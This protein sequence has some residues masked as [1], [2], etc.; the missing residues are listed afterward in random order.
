MLSDSLQEFL[1]ILPFSLDP[2]QLD[3]IES[4]SG[5]RSVLVSAPTGTGKTVVA[6]Y[7][8]HQ[9]LS[10]GLRAIYTTPIKALS[11]QKFRDFRVRYRGPRWPHDRRPG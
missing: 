7:A 5:G 1:G 8:V 10:R 11:N 3:A 4:L 6:E 2:F 9:A